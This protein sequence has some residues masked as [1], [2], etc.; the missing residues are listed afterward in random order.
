MGEALVL[1]DAGGPDLLLVGDGPEVPLEEAR[2][3]GLDDKPKFPGAVDRHM[4]ASVI[5]FLERLPN[6]R[7]ASFRAIKKVV[8]GP[9]LRFVRRDL[10]N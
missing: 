1:K 4:E 6:S 2:A 5:A 7:Q 10:E 9:F 8:L 3:G